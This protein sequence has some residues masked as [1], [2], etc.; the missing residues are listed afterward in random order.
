MKPHPIRILLGIVLLAVA[1]YSGAKFLGIQR[2]YDRGNQAYHA[3]SSLAIHKAFSAGTSAEETAESSQSASQ[4]SNSAPLQ[5]DFAQLKAINPQVMGWIYILDTQ[6]NYPIVHGE[7][8][9][10][11]LNHLV[12]GSENIAGSIFLDARNQEGFLE[13]N[14]ILY[15]HHMKNGSMFAGLKGYKTQDFF[16]AHP[17]GYLIT[18]EASYCIDFF[19]GYVAN[20]EENAWEIDFP[21]DASFGRWLEEQKG[22]S[23]F[24]SPI[25]P[26]Q[27]SKILTLTTC[28]YEFDNARF[29][30]SGVLT[31]LEAA[32]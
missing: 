28:S 26:S 18:E 7:D 27:D 5:I 9:T 4:S 17:T 25:T 32:H 2:K 23:M 21:D 16:D 14:S 22:K 24:T 15:G 13:R 29:V 1:L 20:V 31:K 19:S 11:Y 30:L 8:N 12:D 10:Y 6:I 3:L